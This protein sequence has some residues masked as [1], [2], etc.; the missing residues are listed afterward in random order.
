MAKYPR[1]L[2][3]AWMTNSMPSC[4]L[5]MVTTSVQSHVVKQNALFQQLLYAISVC[6]ECSSYLPEY[7]EY[8]AGDTQVFHTAVLQDKKKKMNKKTK[9]YTTVH[10][11]LSK[12]IHTSTKHRAH[13][14]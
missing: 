12:I 5:G 13:S 1:E 2:I 10:V 6:K 7:D 8:D 14:C 11:L 9:M 4:Y 3:Q